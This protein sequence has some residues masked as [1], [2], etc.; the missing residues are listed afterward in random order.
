MRRCSGYVTLGLENECGK[1]TGNEGCL[2]CPKLA[3]PNT[4]GKETYGA[5][6]RC[7]YMLGKKTI[8]CP[9]DRLMTGGRK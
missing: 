3:I 7:R 5:G 8:I 1:S 6:L 4:S 2:L 9:R